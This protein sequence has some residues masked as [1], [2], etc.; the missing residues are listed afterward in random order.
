MP[1]V[2]VLLLLISHCSSHLAHTQQQCQEHSR[3]TL[4][5]T[6]SPH[7]THSLTGKFTKPSPAIRSRCCGHCL[8]PEH[9]SLHSPRASECDDCA[10]RSASPH[11]SLHSGCTSP[12]YTTNTK[13]CSHHNRKP[14]N[15]LQ[16]VD[17]ISADDPVS[18][19]ERHKDL[20][21]EGFLLECRVALA[22]SAH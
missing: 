22:D 15:Q 16:V 17:I 20:A 9:I 19:R 21:L 8:R 6:T 10:L 3:H 12:D 2:P 14:P 5:I 1:T 11:G 13:V 18:P 4:S 7:S